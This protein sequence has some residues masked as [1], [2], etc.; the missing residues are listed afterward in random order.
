MNGF[1]TVTPPSDKTE[2]GVFFTF[3]LDKNIIYWYFY[4]IKLNEVYYGLQYNS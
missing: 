2:G 3:Q 4:I 1:H